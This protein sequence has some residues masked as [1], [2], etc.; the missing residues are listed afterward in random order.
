MEDSDS[1][2]SSRNEDVVLEVSRAIGVV[3]F[4]ST[5]HSDQNLAGTVKKADIDANETLKQ[6]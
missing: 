5:S 6:F 4:R 1:P 2:D 3:R